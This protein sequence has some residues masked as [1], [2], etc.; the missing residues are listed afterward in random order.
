[1]LYLFQTHA[2]KNLNSHIRQNKRDWVCYNSNL[3]I[4][5]ALVKKLFPSY[6]LF[7]KS[8]IVKCN[9]SVSHVA[10]I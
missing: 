10:V 8:D 5:T 1:M 9:S 3:Q 6:I 7:T 4:I 2:Y